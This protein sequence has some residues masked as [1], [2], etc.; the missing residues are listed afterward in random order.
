[1][2]EYVL[3]EGSPLRVTHA[4]L[5]VDGRWVLD[6]G[7]RCQVCTLEQ[8]TAGVRLTGR[9]PATELPYLRQALQVT[10]RR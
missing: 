2:L 8:F 4:G 7:L 6:S 10:R 3:I 5:L 9:L 1:R